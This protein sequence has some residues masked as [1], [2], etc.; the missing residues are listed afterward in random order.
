MIEILFFIFFL[1]FFI[2]KNSKS[3]PKNN[4][5]HRQSYTHSMIKN[6]LNNK[7]NKKKASQSKKRKE[8]LEIKIL[9]L[10]DKAYWILDNVFYSCKI[11]NG[12]PD[13]SSGEPVDIF[14]MPKKELDKMLIILDNITRGSK[15]DSSGSRD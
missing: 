6:F 10:D 14:N 9:T 5:I 7:N 13:F 4:T 8:S 12:S 11:I 2:Y 1:V 3:K 15:H